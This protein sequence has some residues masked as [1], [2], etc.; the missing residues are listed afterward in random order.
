VTKTIAFFDAGAGA[1]VTEATWA[2]AARWWLGTGVIPDYLNRLEPYADGTAMSVKVR[3]GAVWGDGH[4][5]EETD[6]ETLAIAAANATNPRIDL[7]VLRVDRTLNDIDLAV[8]T[9]TA[10]ATPSVPALTQTAATWEIPLAQ[11]RVNAAVA[12]IAA[13]NVA[14]LR[15]FAGATWL[16]DQAAYFADVLA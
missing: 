15:P 10:A 3:S 9:G 12:T 5:Y 6:E 2:K 13:A 4:Y 8:I 1:N 16:S 11:V 14:D 7:V